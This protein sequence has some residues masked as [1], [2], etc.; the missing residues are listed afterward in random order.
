MEEQPSLEGGSMQRA[1]APNPGVVMRP[2]WTSS[3]A[4]TPEAEHGLLLFE[5]GLLG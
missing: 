5:Q 4:V 3:S 1:G 2:T